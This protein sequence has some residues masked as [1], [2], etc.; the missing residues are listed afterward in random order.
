ME[1]PRLGVGAELQLQAYT[2]AKATPDLNRIWDLHHSSQQRWILNPLSRA[3]DQTCN[4]VPSRI[5]LHCA[6]TGTPF[7]KILF[8]FLFLNGIM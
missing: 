2:T 7:L 8:Y 3:Q 5:H 1:V 6:T 4:L